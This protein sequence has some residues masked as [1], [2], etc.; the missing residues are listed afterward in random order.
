[1]TAEVQARV[2]EVHPELC[3]WG[4]AGHPMQERKSTPGGYEER[5]EA[6]ARVIPVQFPERSGVRRLGLAI[7]P[8]DLL[9]AAAA[10]ATAY[11][12][13]LGKAE[14]IPQQP[15]VDCNGLRMEMVY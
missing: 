3:F 15:E 1:M 8:D 4:F 12:A 6:L 10:A 2:F 7:E 11:R 9:D 14:R 5:R 13:V